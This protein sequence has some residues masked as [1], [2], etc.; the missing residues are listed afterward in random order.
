MKEFGAVS[1]RA[2]RMVKQ[3]LLGHSGGSLE[4]QSTDKKMWMVKVR[5]MRFQ[6]EKDSIGN[7][8]RGCLCCVLA[9]DLAMFCPCSENLGVAGS[10]RN[11]LSR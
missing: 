8:A 6:R 1:Q 5:L 7:L 9:R 4:D 10:N 3:N 2:P 11:G